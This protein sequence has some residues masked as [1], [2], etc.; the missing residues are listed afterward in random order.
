MCF[1]VRVA[2]ASARAHATTWL[3]PPRREDMR[4]TLLV[5]GVTLLTLLHLATRGYSMISSPPPPDYCSCVLH[6]PDVDSCVKPRWL[7]EHTGRNGEV[8]FRLQDWAWGNTMMALR[9][10]LAVALVLDRRPVLMVTPQISPLNGAELSSALEMFGVHVVVEPLESRRGLRPPPQTVRTLQTVSDLRSLLKRPLSADQPVYSRLLFS[11]GFGETYAALHGLA[12]EF[13]GLPG[14]AWADE[15][16]GDDAVP[17]DCWASGFLRPARRVREKVLPLVSGTQAAVHM[18]L[19]SLVNWTDTCEAVQSPHAAARSV[20]RCAV[21][22]ALA[23]S[24]AEAGAAADAAVPPPAGLRLFVSSDSAAVLAGLERDA[25]A[26]NLSL[27]NDGAAAAASGGGG[28]AAARLAWK[29][30]LDAASSGLRLTST[31][32]LRGLGQAMHL[33]RMASEL[34]PHDISPQATLDKAVFDWAAF[35]YSPLAVVSLPSSFPASAVCMFAPRRLSFTVLDL[36]KADDGRVECHAPLAS[37]TRARPGDAQQQH[38]C[39]AL[40]K[41]NAKKLRRRPG[42]TGTGKLVAGTSRRT[43][44]G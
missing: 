4:P 36:P 17:P 20:L 15:L 31:S 9:D 2:L 5:V 19:C 28:G 1:G 38:P 27:S 23:S 13:R 24:S 37:S 34:T 40:Q 14:R 3:Q 11:F 12:R 30:R 43:G 7:T 32:S 41:V 10:A 29:R 16:F 22:R 18:R 42:G 44:R 35:A 33:S 26:A 39:A 6:A 8:Y 25:R 21:R